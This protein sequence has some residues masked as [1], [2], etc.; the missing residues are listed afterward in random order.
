MAFRYEG[1]IPSME[2]KTLRY[3]GHAKH[4]EAIRDLGLLD[5]EPIEVKGVKVVPRE[6]FVNLVGPK[7]TKP[8]GKDLLALRVTVTGTKDGAPAKRQFD[9]IDWYDETHGIS[10]MMRTTGYSLSITGQMQARRQVGA[11][12]VWT[13]DECIPAVEYIAELRKRGMTSGSPSNGIGFRVLASVH[14]ESAIFAGLV[15]PHALCACWDPGC[16]FLHRSGRNK[17]YGRSQHSLRDCGMT[18]FQDGHSLVRTL[19]RRFLPDL[20]S[21]TRCARAGIQGAVL[22]TDIAKTNGYGRSQHSLRDCGMTEFQDGH[23]LAAS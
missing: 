7:L 13:P 11:A 10:A 2:Y 23:S 5:L 17:R 14:P 19:R 9:L 4:M 16:G 8:K 21:R 6:L 15:I 18:E 3:P 22:C 20:S 12:G 1:R